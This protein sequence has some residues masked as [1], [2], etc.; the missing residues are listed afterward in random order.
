MFLSWECQNPM[1]QC[2]LRWFRGYSQETTSQMCSPKLKPPPSP[3]SQQYPATTRAIF[4]WTESCYCASM[5][6]P[7]KELLFIFVLSVISVLCR[8]ALLFKFSSLQ[9]SLNNSFWCLACEKSIWREKIWWIEKK[10]TTQCRHTFKKDDQLWE[11][12]MKT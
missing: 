11:M 6:E 7:T 12:K 5:E 3:Y 10:Y 4:W 2:R 1:P 8:I 9:I